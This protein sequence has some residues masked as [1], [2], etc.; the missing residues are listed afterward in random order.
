[1]RFWDWQSLVQRNPKQPPWLC[2]LQKMFSLPHSS[3]SC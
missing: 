3:W 2:L 1:M